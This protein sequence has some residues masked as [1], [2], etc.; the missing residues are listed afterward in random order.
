MKKIFVASDHAGFELKNALK[1]FLLAQGHEIEDCGPAALDPHDDYPDYVLPCAQKVAQQDGSVGII[2]GLSG[3]GE[4]IAAN[5]VRGA[6]AAVYYGGPEEVLTLSR[7]H[8]NA[9]ILSLGAKFVT[10]EAAQDAVEIWLNT[11]FSAD[12]RHVRRIHKV[13][14]PVYN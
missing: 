6:R 5:R 3:Q 11:D 10:L 4:A 7:Q 1:D 14:A 8:N 2:I 9:N 13:D 12:E